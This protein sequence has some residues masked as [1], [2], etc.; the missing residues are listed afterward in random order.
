MEYLPAIL[1]V[2]SVHFLALISPGPDFI[3]TVQSSLLRSRKAGIYTALGLATGMGIHVIYSLAGIGFLISRSILLFSVM[4]Y[5]GAAYLIYLGY[6]A[7]RSKKESYSI[8]DGDETESTFGQVWRAAFITN[9][10]NPKVTLFFLSVF[11]LVISPNTPLYI[12]LIMGL[13]MTLATFLWFS[14][15]AIVFSH[16]ALQ[17]RVQNV[18]YYAE[19][20]LGAML[21]LLGL[22]LATASR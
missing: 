17:G 6:R 18:Q 13:E 9:V 22:K 8:K 7:L 3:L 20:F 12:Q 15:V 10:T 1:T 16:R 5:L 21:I 19:K 14:L 11:T 4:K 2:A